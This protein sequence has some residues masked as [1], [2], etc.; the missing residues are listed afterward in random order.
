[1]NILQR[2]S[3]G[4]QD[5]RHR[6]HRRVFL[7]RRFIRPSDRH[8]ERKSFFLDLRDG[9]DSRRLADREAHHIVRGKYGDRSQGKRLRNG[10]LPAVGHGYLRGRIDPCERKFAFGHRCDHGKTA[11]SEGER[12]AFAIVW[13]GVSVSLSVLPMGVLVCSIPSAA[14]HDSVASELSYNPEANSNNPLAR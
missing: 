9:S 1:M 5:L 12:D 6:E 13:L 3:C 14:F 4:P 2:K 10:P 7:S 8:F 11:G